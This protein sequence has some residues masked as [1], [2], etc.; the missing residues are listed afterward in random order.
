VGAIQEGFAQNLRE[1]T[2]TVA[3]YD[4]MMGQLRHSMGAIQDSIGKSLQPVLVEFAEKMQPIIEQ[5]GL[6]IVLNPE[7]ARNRILAGL[8]VTG[9][10]TQVITLSLAMVAINPI[11]LGIGVAIAGMV[12]AIWTMNEAIKILQNDWD[13]VW[14]GIL[15]TASN[16]ANSVIGVFE[17]MTNFIIDAINGALASINKMIN[18]LKDIPT[19]GKAFKGLDNIDMIEKVSL[20]RIDSQRFVAPDRVAGGTTI[21]NNI[22]GNSFMTDEEGAEQIGDMIMSKLRLNTSY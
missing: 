8:A 12:Y 11:A 7:L 20:G 13:L 17:G 15:I 2:D 16:V 5:V 9:L 18:R 3:G 22:T 4:V 19:I 1:T 6:W 14:S 10:T 21:V